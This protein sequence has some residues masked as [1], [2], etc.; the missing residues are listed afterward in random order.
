LTTS[1]ADRIRSELADHDVSAD[2][3]RHVDDW[4]AADKAF[5]VWFLETTK[6]ALRDD[7]LMELLDGYRESQ[8]IIERAWEDFQHRRNAMM[9]I[10]GI[11]QS[12]HR[13][14]LLQDIG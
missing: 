5:N 4:I 12:I 8:E 11:T 9:L 13:M 10:E 1:V 7:E 6:R 3:R 14:K 2:V